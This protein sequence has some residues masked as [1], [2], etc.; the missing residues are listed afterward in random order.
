MDD[1]YTKKI[2]A[3]AADIPFDKRLDAPDITVTK[4]SRICGSRLTVDACLEEGRII[5]LG[6]NVKACIMG[7]AC[8][9]IVTRH[10]IGM[11]K[12]ELLPVADAFEA[13]V[14]ENVTPSWPDDKWRD[15]EIFKELH[16]N[17]NPYGSV[18]LVFECLR[19][20]FKR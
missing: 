11:T 19:E 16:G 12:A 20:V 3:L 5:A 10:V 1:I 2:L 15:L 18:M 7:Q 8:A 17:N 6:Q 4:V 9:S 14:K 13:M